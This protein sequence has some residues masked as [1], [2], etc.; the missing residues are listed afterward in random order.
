VTNKNVVI[1]FD[2]LTDDE[3]RRLIVQ[4]CERRGSSVLSIVG[5][6]ELN[7]WTQGLDDYDLQKWF[8]D[9]CARREADGFLYFDEYH[10]GSQGLTSMWMLIKLAGMDK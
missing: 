4:E 5:T 3:F 10:V 7:T 1:G 2:S 9:E 6:D 8:I